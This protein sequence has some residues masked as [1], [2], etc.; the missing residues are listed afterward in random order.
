MATS[1]SKSR[2]QEGDYAAFDFKFVMDVAE[3]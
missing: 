3:S 1:P 2:V